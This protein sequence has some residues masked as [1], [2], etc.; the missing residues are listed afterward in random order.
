MWECWAERSMGGEYFF[1][2]EKSDEWWEG[3]ATEVE[4][5][6]AEEEIPDHRLPGTHEWEGLFFIHWGTM[7]NWAQCLIELSIVWQRYVKDLHKAF[8]SKMVVNFLISN[9]F[10][11]CN[12]KDKKILRSRK[13]FDLQLIAFNILP[14]AIRI[15]K[16]KKL[17]FSQNK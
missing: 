10:I 3:K 8:Q 12:N 2:V 5:E 7:S 11:V 16:P 1:G 6:P 15:N 4:T 13:A 17:S 9:W 14:R